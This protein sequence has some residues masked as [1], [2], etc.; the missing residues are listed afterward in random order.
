MSFGLEVS[1]G[2]VEACSKYAEEHGSEF[3]IKDERDGKGSSKFV[4]GD[5]YKDDFLE[6]AGLDPGE[7]FDLIY[8]YT[9][10]CAMNPSMRPAWA[11]R[12]SDL[13]ADSAT[14]HLV[15][16]EFPT[17]KPPSSGGPPHS[18]PSKAYIEHLSHPG[19]DV[20]Y[21]EEG[22]VKYQPLA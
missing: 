22:N 6:D 9:F 8:D 18:S 3:P 17:D 15:C 20:P 14:A 5:F 1:E 2:A 12:M 11:Q 13:L 16:L 10:F 4:L 19:E 21:D 7:K